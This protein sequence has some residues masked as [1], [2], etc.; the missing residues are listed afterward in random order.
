MSAP[1]ARCRFVHAEYDVRMSKS[2]GAENL[3]RTLTSRITYLGAELLKDAVARDP[4][5]RRGAVAR[6]ALRRRLALLQ[7]EVDGKPRCGGA[8]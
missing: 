2:K 7:G 3:D 8:K 6:E 1:I 4:L 5:A